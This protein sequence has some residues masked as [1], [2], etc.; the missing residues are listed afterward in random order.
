MQNAL[1]QA[2][3]VASMDIPLEVTLLPALPRNWPSGS[4]KGARIRGG[5]SLDLIWEGGKPG[6]A[7]FTVDC[8][9]AGRVRDVQV[10]YAGRR[11]IGEFRNYP[12]VIKTFVF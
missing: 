9:V 8:D 12:G 7:K 4:I 3:D 11:I 6:I 5:I 1:V 10:I 2:P